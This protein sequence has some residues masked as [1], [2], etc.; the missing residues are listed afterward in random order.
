LLIKNVLAKQ[1]TSKLDLPEDTFK[2]RVFLGLSFLRES[3]YEMF[4]NKFYPKKP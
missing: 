3:W 2:E 4:A 1:R